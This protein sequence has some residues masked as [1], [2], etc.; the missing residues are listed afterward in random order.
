MG[1]IGNYADLTGFTVGNFIVVQ[2]A[3][4]DRSKAPVWC[5]RCKLCG[6]EQVFAHSKLTNRLETRSAG[7]TLFCQNQACS[8]SR[9]EPVTTESLRDVRRA[10]VEQRKQSERIET[11]RRD[12]ASQEAADKAAREAALA[13]MRADWHRYVINR[14]NAGIA[15]NQILNFD[16]W[17]QIGDAA[18]TRF[19][20]LVTQAES[21][22]S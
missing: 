21:Q 10:E 14:I 13:P 5:V 20:H 4:R 1:F 8:L 11:E 22:F 19:M 2:L 17:Q 18:R 3:G 7:E 6:R 9:K 15:A 12:R 16:R